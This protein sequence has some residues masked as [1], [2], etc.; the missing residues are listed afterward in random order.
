[1][2]EKFV[3]LPVADFRIRFARVRFH[4]WL[5]F[6]F[7]HALRQRTAVVRS[8]G[9]LPVN[10]GWKPAR[11]ASRSEALRVAAG[12]NPRTD[13]Q[14]GMMR[15]GATPERFVHTPTFSRRY[16]TPLRTDAAPWVET[17]GYPHSVAP[18]RHRTPQPNRRCSGLQT[19]AG[20]LRHMTGETPVP[21]LGA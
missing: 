11:A 17:H 12:F 7:A 8:A 18:R 6:V 16:A 20:R 15:L 19:Q 1:M 4:E 14:T 2:P 10:A 3:G 5:V 21:R 9:I 13:P